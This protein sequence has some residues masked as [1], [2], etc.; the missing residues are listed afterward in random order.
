MSATCLGYIPSVR[1]QVM[2][3]KCHVPGA[4][5]CSEGDREVWVVRLGGPE[6]LWKLEWQGS[7]LGQPRGL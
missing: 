7:V 6:G 1:G 4:Q 5:G 2:V 3:G